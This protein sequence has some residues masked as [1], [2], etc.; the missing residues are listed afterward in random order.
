ML[1]VALVCVPPAYN[2]TH[3]MR[4]KDQVDQHL[5]QSHEFQVITKSDKPGWWS[6]IDLFRPRRFEGRVLY[7]DLDT[8]IV[9]S[10]DDIADYPHPFA[11]SGDWGK[12]R[13]NSSVMV[14][15]AGVADHI[16]N[17]FTSDVMDRLHGD[18]DWIGEQMPDATVFPLGWIAS[19]KATVLRRGFVPSASRVVVFHGQ[20]KPWSLHA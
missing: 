1:T 15:D 7:L 17:N 4:L 19:Y 11:I 3:V 9:G 12:S 16:Y 20:P 2:N 13:Y 8:E 5:D 10:L 18:Q 6:K 14:W